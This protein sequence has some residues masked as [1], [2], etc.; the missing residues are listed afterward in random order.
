MQKGYRYELSAPEG[1]NFDSNFKPELTPQQMLELGVF[2]GKYMTDTPKEFPES[3][4]K[5]AKL[6]PTGRDCSLNYFGVECQPTAIRVAKQRMDTPRRS[7]RLVPMVLPLLPRSPHAGRRQA[8]D[9]PLEGLP[10]TR[11]TGTNEL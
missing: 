4:F 8:A 2:C 6:S 7:T 5:H 3:W 11:H 1:R 10:A 9:Q